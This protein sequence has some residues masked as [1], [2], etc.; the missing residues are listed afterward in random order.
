MIIILKHYFII[1]F[2]QIQEN[3]EKNKIN[4]FYMRTIVHVI[5]IFVLLFLFLGITYKT[6]ERFEGFNEG[7]NTD[8]P[9]ENYSPRTKIPIPVAMDGTPY[10]SPNSDGDCPIG[11]TRDK[12]D[13]NSLCHGG[14]EQGKFYNVDE[15]IYGCVVL[16]NDYPRDNY[17]DK[18]YPFAYDKKTNIVSPTSN[19]RCPYNFKLDIRSGLCHTRCSN[20]DQTFYGKYGCAAIN[21]NY[22]QTEYDGSNNPYPVANDN[23]TKYVSPSTNLYCP[24]GFKFDYESGLCYTDCS[25]GTKFSGKQSGSTIPGCY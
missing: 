14:C 7:F 25:G 12:N 23:V 9:R 18:D 10:M 2:E 21:K 8:F 13:E 20:D 1:V 24:S 15:N 5:I 6:Y 11:Y 22:P 19:A 17:P 16:N 3:K 4:V